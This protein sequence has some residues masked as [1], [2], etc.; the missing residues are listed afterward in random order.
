MDKNQIIHDLA[1]AY[2]KTKLEEFQIEQREA[3]AVGNIEMSDN[4]IKVLKS[5]YDFAIKNLS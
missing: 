2:A 1:V 4:E 3:L 5:A